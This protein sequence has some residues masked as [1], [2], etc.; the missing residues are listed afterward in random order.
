MKYRHASFKMT[1]W[2]DW[3]ESGFQIDFDFNKAREVMQSSL[4]VCLPMGSR[5]TQKI[6]RGMLIKFSFKIRKS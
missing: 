1:D 2:Y 4:F 5:I 6:G 3:C